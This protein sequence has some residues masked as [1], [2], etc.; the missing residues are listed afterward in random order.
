MGEITV[1]TS[2]YIIQSMVWTWLVQSSLFS[3]S[4]KFCRCSVS[5]LHRWVKFIFC[6]RE[7][8]VFPLP[9]SIPSSGGNENNRDVLRINYII[10]SFF[11]VAWT[12]DLWRSLFPE[13]LTCQ[14]GTHDT[15]WKGNSTDSTYR[16]LFIRHG[17]HYCI[18]R[19]EKGCTKPF[20]TPEGAGWS[21]INCLKWCQRRLGR[22]TT[23]FWK[24]K[25]DG[26]APHPATLATFLA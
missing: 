16:S 24:W 1:A 22:K 19:G 4:Q 13:I 14:P 23:S 2:T 25:K 12:F 6:T 26:F 15:H 17:E 3:S 7:W 11:S 18:C 8:I 20:V 10:Q 5:I 9:Q 21:V